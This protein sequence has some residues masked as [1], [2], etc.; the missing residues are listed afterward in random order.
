MARVHFYMNNPTAG[1]QDGTLISENG[2]QTSPL[3]AVLDATQAESTI[4]KVAARCEAGYKTVDNTVIKASG[5]TASKWSFAR[6]NNYSDPQAAAT[7]DFLDTITLPS[8]IEQ[9][10]VIFWVKVI[11]TTDEQPVRDTSVTIN[12]TTK[13]SAS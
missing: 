2:A 4:I 7:A 5:T 8:G 1:V 9:S 6:D 10:N 12:Y 13:V 3:Q 11:S